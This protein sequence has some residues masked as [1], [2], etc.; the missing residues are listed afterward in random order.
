MINLTK[1]VGQINNIPCNVNKSTNFGL[2]LEQQLTNDT[3]VKNTGI[4]LKRKTKFSEEVASIIKCG[5]NRSSVA[6]SIDF[7]KFKKIFGFQ[8]LSP[9]KR[10]LNAFKYGID[11]LYKNR[12]HIPKEIDALLIGHGE[13]SFL[14]ND[15]CFCEN[16]KSVMDYLNS[17][18]GIGKKVLVFTCESANNATKKFPG[19]G[20]EVINTLD[21]EMHPA[22]IVE[23]G[24]GIIGHFVNNQ[25]VYY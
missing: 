8:L 16:G 9:T 19:I 4:L 21:D 13:G 2:Q 17:T 18:L 3:F 7:E 25:A 23:T 10:G 5:H 6:S 12:K 11:S 24:K 15:W 14:K 22:K 20:N 1:L